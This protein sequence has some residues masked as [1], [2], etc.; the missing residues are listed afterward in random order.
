MVMKKIL[1]P[2]DFS[3]NAHN[4]LNY[5]TFIADKLKSQ[6]I[7]FNFF[8][9]PLTAGEVPIDPSLIEELENESIDTLHQLKKDVLEKHP[10]LDIKCISS[11]GLDNEVNEICGVSDNNRVDLVVMGTKGASGITKALIGSNAAHVIDNSNCPVLAIPEFATF[12]GIKKIVY[13]TDFQAADY[14]SIHFLK[15]LASHFDAEIIIV[16]I[17][18]EHHSVIHEANQLEQFKQDLS[19]ITST[20]KITFELIAGEDIQQRLNKLIEVNHADIISMSTHKR[21]LLQRLFD[22]SLTKKMAYHTHIPLLAFH[23]Q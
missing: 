4:A 3:D 19:K 11:S 9:V 7:L 6:I 17:A 21:N 2:T 13:A 8:R 23:I 18:D 5:A 22:R 10:D 14:Q 16:H 12:K 1:V 20:E 15:E